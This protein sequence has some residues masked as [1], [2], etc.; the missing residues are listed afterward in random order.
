ML[1]PIRWMYASPED[2]QSLHGNGRRPASYGLAAP[3]GTS[4]YSGDFKKVKRKAWTGSSTTSQRRAFCSTVNWLP[5]YAL[6]E[7]HCQETLQWSYRISNFSSRCYINYKIHSIQRGHQVATRLS[8]RKTR[9][10]YLNVET[11][12]NGKNDNET[13][14]VIKTHHNKTDKNYNSLE[15]VGYLTT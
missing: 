9:I 15:N 2:A 1:T 3:V 14:K 8:V 10:I 6:K 12:R 11:T 7:H 4:R 5:F 13:V